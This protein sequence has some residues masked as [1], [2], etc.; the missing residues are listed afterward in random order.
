MPSTRLRTR[1]NKNRKTTTTTR[2]CLE[3]RRGAI[4]ERTIN[5]QPDESV[6]TALALFRSN[7]SFSDFLEAAEIEMGASRLAVRGAIRAGSQ[8]RK[9]LARRRLTN[10]VKK[11]FRTYARRG[12]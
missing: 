4:A 11:G 7:R 3:Y 1:D 10:V 5:N 8:P 12:G 2:N 6:E 9:S